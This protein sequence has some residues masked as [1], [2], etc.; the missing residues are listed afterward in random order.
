MET[1]YPSFG[2]VSATPEAEDT[3][4]VTLKVTENPVISP[5]EGDT[6][7]VQLE[8]I[9]WAFPR[10]KFKQL[11]PNSMFVAALESSSDSIIPLENPVVTAE[12][13]S[14]L[15]FITKYGFT[16]P[17]FGMQTRQAGAYL[18]IPI[19]LVASNPCL[20]H[21]PK[22]GNLLDMTFMKQEERYWPL[23]SA[24][25]RA[26]DV[27]V[28]QYIFGVIPAEMT[29]DMDGMLMI[30][31]TINGW[32]EVFRVLMHRGLK[33]RQIVKN[34]R[35]SPPYIG[36]M[37]P[38][39]RV[40]D[41]SD[42]LD[43]VERLAQTF[44]QKQREDQIP[45]LVLLAPVMMQPGHMAILKMLLETVG[46]PDEL[47]LSMTREYLSRANVGV[48]TVKMLLSHLQRIEPTEL[49]GL[50]PTIVERH[51]A[52]VYSYIHHDLKVPAGMD[53]V[54][55]MGDIAE[56]QRFLAYNQSD[57]GLA[58]MIQSAVEEGHYDVA[59]ILLPK[60]FT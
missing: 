7:G 2:V 26:G 35:H 17:P 56:V 21:I 49:V 38:D 10:N 24:A 47:I 36:L 55:A 53:H 39:E 11:F 28:L 1:K 52:E 32:S 58:Q 40:F 43:V 50:Y 57:A 42:K 60:L 48:E 15:W 41:Y 14:Y 5:S 16:L 45:Y 34:G 27:E 13:L 31:A 22:L 46:L 37:V 59:A 4:S 18:G 8:R 12:I 9:S 20:R 29:L 30:E 44:L 25:A 6:T 3:F 19:L 23:V 51:L 54:A 33:P